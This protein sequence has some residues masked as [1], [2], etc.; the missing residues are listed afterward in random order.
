MFKRFLAAVF[1]LGLATIA[2]GIFVAKIFGT[3]VFCW[4]GSAICGIVTISFC[5]SA[6]YF[7]VRDGD[8]DKLL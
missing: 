8:L 4:I 7:I 6:A 5:L 3:D 2:V 1:L